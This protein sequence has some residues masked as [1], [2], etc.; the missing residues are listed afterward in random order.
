MIR[1]HVNGE[2]EDVPAGTTL[3]ALIEA[4]GLAP[5]QVAAEVNRDLVPRDA[6]GER[7]LEGGDRIELVTMVGGG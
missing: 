2:R 3:A 6:R 7:V 4:R 5:D 1:I